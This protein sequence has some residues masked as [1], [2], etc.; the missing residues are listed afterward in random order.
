[1]A[2][3][4]CYYYFFPGTSA[5]RDT[6][7]TKNGGNGSGSVVTHM[8][9]QHGGN[10]HWLGIYLPELPCGAVLAVLVVYDVEMMAHMRLK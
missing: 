2:L 8:I 6:L 9:R 10:W 4:V 7:G 5:K 1:M 3:L